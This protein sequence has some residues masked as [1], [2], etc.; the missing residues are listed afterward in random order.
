MRFNDAVFG[1]VLLLAAV[2]V[3]AVARGFPGMP[4]QNFGPAL[5]PDLIAAGLLPVRCRAG[6]ERAAASRVRRRSS[7]SVT[8]PGAAA[9]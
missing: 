6:L 8:G 2:A 3:F 5:F 9:T 4:G 7:R 1:V